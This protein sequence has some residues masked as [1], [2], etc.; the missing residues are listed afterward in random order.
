[1]SS[2]IKLTK[3]NEGREQHNGDIIS[4]VRVTRHADLPWIERF[5]GHGSVSSKTQA[6]L[7][8]WRNWSPRFGLWLLTAPHMQ[9]N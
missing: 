8:Q 6:S 3:E 4:R 1:M 7:C 5:L 9:R 2:T